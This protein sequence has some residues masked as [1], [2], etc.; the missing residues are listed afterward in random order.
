[1]QNHLYGI[2]HRL[3]I[4]FIEHLIEVFQTLESKMITDLVPYCH[5][6]VRARTSC[7]SF[8]SID[9]LIKNQFHDHF[10]PNVKL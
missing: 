5:V 10:I 6:T 9:E 4:L 1:M 2:S 3:D 7:P 8:K